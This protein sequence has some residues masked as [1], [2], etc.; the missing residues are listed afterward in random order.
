MYLYGTS[1]TSAVRGERECAGWGNLSLWKSDRFGH[2]LSR[3]IRLRVFE[4][5]RDRWSNPNDAQEELLSVAGAPA[6]IDAFALRHED[7]S[8]SIL[9]VNR[10]S[11]AASVKLSA[12]KSM[13]GIDSSRTII[14]H[15]M[16]L[17]ELPASNWLRET[18]V[19]L[20][21]AIEIQPES[22]TILTANNSVQG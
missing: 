9:L 22:L 13:T 4:V 14:V 5:L 6:G 17:P 16:G 2:I 19:P 18:R 3:S 21:A 8:V 10:T 20:P 11:K 7:S 12:P 1:P 15:R